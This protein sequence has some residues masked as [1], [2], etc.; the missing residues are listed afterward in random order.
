MSKRSKKCARLPALCR[1]EPC[2]QV[3]GLRPLTVAAFAV[4][5]HSALCPIESRLSSA[6]WQNV[7]AWLISDA[8]N[9]RPGTSFHIIS[10][11][12]IYALT[13][14]I[15]VYSKKSA[16]LCRRQKSHGLYCHSHFAMSR[17][18]AFHKRFHL[19]T[20]PEYRALSALTSTAG[21]CRWPAE[22]FQWSRRRSGGRNA[23]P[24]V[25]SRSRGCRRHWPSPGGGQKTP[26]WSCHQGS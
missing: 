16:G 25:R 10:H 4:C 26:S 13:Y 17:K 7:C 22:C 1:Y 19:P 5:I 24:R 21:S 14:C 9:Q 2:R 18:K 15:H 23:L 11:R 20:V 3:R 8:R 6:K 12:Y